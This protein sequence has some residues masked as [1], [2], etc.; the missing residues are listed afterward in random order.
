[1][2]SLQASLGF[3]DLSKAQILVESLEVTIAAWF[4]MLPPDKRGLIMKSGSESCLVDQLMF[5]AHMMMYT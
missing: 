1:M 2:S 4:V 3:Q 5:Q